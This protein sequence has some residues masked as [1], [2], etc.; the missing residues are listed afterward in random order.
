MTFNPI[1]NPLTGSGGTPLSSEQSSSKVKKLTPIQQIDKIE[2]DIG[3][4]LE[5]FQR[6]S[7]DDVTKN[8]LVE[9]QDLCSLLFNDPNIPASVKGDLTTINKTLGD[10][11]NAHIANKGKNDNFLETQI[12][13][14]SDAAVR[15]ENVLNPS[16]S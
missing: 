3:A 8:K 1:N 14:C 2:A 9:A 4:V 16:R 15:V 10:V 5:D 7:V 12:S 13:A 11:W 6:G